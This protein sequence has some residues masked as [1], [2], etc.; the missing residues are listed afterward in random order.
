LLVA[1]PQQACAVARAADYPQLGDTVYLNTASYGPMPRRAMDAIRAFE[2]R[3]ATVA[4]HPDDFGGALD[5]ARS[6]CARLIG[7]DADEIALVPNTS[8]GVNLAAVFLRQRAAR[9]EQRRTII[10][11]DG[12]FPANVYPWLA[13]EEDGFRVERLPLD[14]R[15]CP[16][17]DA[18]VERLSRGDVA[19]L[20]VSAVQFATGWNAD[21]V[22]LG[23]ACAEFGAL[24]AVDAIQAV[25]A[26]AIDVRAA[27]IDVLA[28]G[29]HKWLCGPFGTG[30]AWVRRELC[31]Q[32][33]PDLPGWLAFESSVDFAS[34]TSYRRDLWPDARRFEVGSLA[35]QGFIG[36]AS[37]AELLAEIGVDRIAEHVRALLQP[38]VDW[39]AADGS[40]EPIVADGPSR[41]AILAV[42]VPDAAAT[43]AA[44]EARGIITVPREGAVRF[45]PHFFNTMD[46]TQRV[47]SVLQSLPG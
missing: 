30:F 16:D 36:L 32:H 31:R 5:R 24:F 29:G 13:L 23:A 1:S 46:E 43:S 45:A 10:M 41:S 4:L 3:R 18:L 2:D 28:C 19:A 38:I 12:E 26:T 42:R 22:R 15:G 34:L 35:I 44:L 6:A 21:L 39:A 27:R 14:P 47:V 9:G 8:T 40:A 11:P 37:S 7:G 25:G 17:E 20:A 33:H